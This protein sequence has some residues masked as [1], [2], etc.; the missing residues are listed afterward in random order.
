MLAQ[1]VAM[2]AQSTGESPY[3]LHFSR[4]LRDRSYFSRGLRDRSYFS[5]GLRDRG[6]RS[7]RPQLLLPRSTRPRPPVY[8]A[9]AI[10]PKHAFR[11]DLPMGSCT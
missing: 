9:A 3:V 1:V 11:Q 7:T 6:H 5:R 4:G 10:G 2:L 8:A